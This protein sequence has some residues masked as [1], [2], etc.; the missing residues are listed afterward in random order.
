MSDAPPSF[1]P[2][3]ESA[4]NSVPLGV[5]SGAATQATHGYESEMPLPQFNWRKNALLFVATVL[6]VFYVGQSWTA[7]AEQSAWQALRGAWV[8]A[9]PLMTILVAH[10]LGHYIAA[11][12]HRVPA[13][14]P[15]FIPFPI[16][17]PFGTMGAV[18]VM[19]RRIRSA[20][21]LL[22]IGAAGPLAGMAVAIPV[23]LFGLSLSQ[24][25]PRSDVGYI[26]EGQSLLYWAL[27]AAVFGHI[28][29][30]QDVQLHPTALAA[31]AGFLVTFLNM[32]PLGQL[33]GGHV[34]Y[35]LF[36]RRQNR[37]AAWV[38]FAPVVMFLYNAVVHVLPIVRR[39]FAEGFSKLGGQA[40]MPVSAC[41]VW[42]TVFILLLVMRRASGVG[43]PPVDDE[44][45]SP[46]RKVVAV[47][48]L[49]MFV[50]IFMPSPWV[51]Y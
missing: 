25:G 22:D 8:F 24:L 16:L 3:V 35:A 15:Y 4:P 46:V 31:W 10:E 40:W 6:S 9:V 29:P 17:N 26:Q 18:I 21:A 1:P 38:L 19:P 44:K 23:M 34:A 42:I 50:A 45:L 30:D 27:K 7:T 12:I 20:N 49:L 41:T 5:G 37:I 2:V 28:A 36:G 51:V 39:G 33:D 48:T 32:I 14:L 47:G 43:H 11:R 13:S